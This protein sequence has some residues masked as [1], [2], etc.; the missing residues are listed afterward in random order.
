[1][2]QTAIS[3]AF[4]DIMVE[5]SSGPNKQQVRDSDWQFTESR[6]RRLGDLY[7]FALDAACKAAAKNGGAALFA[8]I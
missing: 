2:R 6:H 3:G 1:M 7:L 5:L 4:D 8:T